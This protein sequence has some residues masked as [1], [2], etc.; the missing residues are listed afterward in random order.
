[1]RTGLIALAF[2]GAV[3]AVPQAAHAQYKNTSFVIDGGYEMLTR[4]PLPSADQAVLNAS[5]IPVRLGRGTR[6]GLEGNFKM[7]TDHWWISPRVNFH[8]LDFTSSGDDTASAVFDNAAASTVGTVLGLEGVVGVRYYILT[9]R[10]RPFLQPS[11][12]YMYL[13]QF[14]DT[15]NSSC[16]GD[17]TGLCGSSGSDLLDTYLPHRNIL[18]LQAKFGTEFVFTRD[19][20]F[21]VSIDVQ[22]WFI[23]NAAD[24][25]VFTLSGGFTIY[26]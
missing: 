15:T 3:L 18:A 10:I 1:M 21:H 19:V 12:S 9:D 7:Q 26:G 17:V 23:V 24:N 25:T 11:L 20:A 22:R 2:A 13:F 8:L 6:I 16:V 14:S 5:S 4:P